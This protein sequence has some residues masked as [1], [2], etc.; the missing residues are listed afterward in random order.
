MLRYCRWVLAL[1]AVGST[2]GTGWAADPFPPAALPGISLGG[3]LPAGYETSGI[4]WHSRL[5]KLFLV[6]DGGTVSSMSANGTGVTNWSVGGDLEGITVAQPQRDFIYLGIEHPDSI[7][8]FNIATGQVTRTFNLTGWMT[9]ADNSGLEALT[10]VPD[11]SNPE[12]GLFYAGLQATGEIFVFQ[13]PVVSS[14]TSTA[15][16]HVRTISALN[17]VSDIS[18]MH[19]EASQGVLYAIYD[20]ANLLRAMKPDGTLIKEWNL[21]GNDQE[22]L[23]LKGT[24]LYIGEDYGNGGN[25]FRYSPFVGVPE[26]STLVLLT[27]GLLGLPAYAWRRKRRA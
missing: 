2:N 8:E 11:A 6:S 20:S 17:G 4:V 13:L 25:V 9:G 16:T 12:G 24:D 19:Y 1:A 18:D 23:T 21:P 22:G 14:T 5:Q 10:F 26:P 27:A 3:N 15:V 7:S